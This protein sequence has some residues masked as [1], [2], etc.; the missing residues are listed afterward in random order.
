[1]REIKFRAWCKPDDMAGHMIS[2]G[3]IKI[4]FR[5]YLNEETGTDTHR[6]TGRDQYFLMQYTGIK[7]KNGVEIYEGDIVGMFSNS[8]QSE[9]WFE[10]GSYFITLQRSG[11]SDPSE[12]LL[13][14]HL[15]ICE[16]IGNIYE[17]PELVEAK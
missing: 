1:M 13:S 8:Q 5:Q 2:W 6:K 17:N 7:D 9:V 10:D 11:G 16:V 14:N 3:S 15:S 12:D 4:N